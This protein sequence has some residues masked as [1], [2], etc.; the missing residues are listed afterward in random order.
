MWLFSATRW[1][2]VREI[3]R[4]IVM[5]LGYP[6]TQKFAIEYKAGEVWKSR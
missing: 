2:G 4:A 5:E 1:A 3:G 6:R